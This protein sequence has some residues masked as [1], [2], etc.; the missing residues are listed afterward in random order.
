[1]LRLD[2]YHHFPAGSGSADLKLDKILA[3]LGVLMTTVDAIK[4]LVTDIDTETNAVASKVDAQAAE[5]KRL[6]DL[7]AAGGTV[8]QADLD[9]IADGLTPISD[10]LKAIGADSLNPIPPQV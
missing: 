1:M 7:I 5:I 9:A 8:T 10:R 3:Q 4:K 2:V 6:S